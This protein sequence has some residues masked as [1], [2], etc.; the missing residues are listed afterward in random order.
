MAERWPACSVIGLERISL[1]WT[2]KVIE[3]NCL[4]RDSNP[5]CI[6]CP[7]VWNEEE[8]SKLLTA[9]VSRAAQWCS[10]IQKLWDTP[11]VSINLVVT[12]HFKGQKW[13]YSPHSTCSVACESQN[14]VGQYCRITQFTLF[15]F[16]QG[17]PT[18]AVTLVIYIVSNIYLNDNNNQQQREKYIIPQGG[19]HSSWTAK[20]EKCS[21]PLALPLELTGCRQ[22]ILLH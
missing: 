13:V 5:I 19:L 12:Q 6:C 7:W 1:I 9:V 21:P 4:G 18:E 17:S 10:L 2:L 22:K 15:A 8:A 16:P 11:E 20:E 3:Q 14:T